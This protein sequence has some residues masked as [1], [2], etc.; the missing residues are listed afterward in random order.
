MLL[1]RNKYINIKGLLNKMQHPW[2]EGM[3]RIIEPDSGD[4]S[5]VSDKLAMWHRGQSECPTT[6]GHIIHMNK[7]KIY[8]G[9]Y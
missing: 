1:V 6:R 2:K 7:Y 4:Y 8:E 9:D 3:W 5:T